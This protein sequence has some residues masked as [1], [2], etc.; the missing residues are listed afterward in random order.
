MI[1]REAQWN[2][3]GPWSPCNEHCKR[4][5]RRQCQ[6]TPRA[7]GYECSGP[8]INT[9]PCDPVFCR[10]LAGQCQPPSLFCVLKCVR[11]IMNLVRLNT[12]QNSL[13]QVLM[14]LF[15]LFFTQE[16]FCQLASIKV[17]LSQ[18]NCVDVASFCQLNFEWS[19]QL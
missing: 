7:E 12:E 17:T 13:N 8:F 2:E 14:F 5:R 4:Q 19:G 18:E 1:S 10:H 16:R 3:W 11:D 15:S 6:G 9:Q